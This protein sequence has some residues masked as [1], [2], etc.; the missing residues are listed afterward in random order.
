MVVRG[1]LRVIDSSEVSVI[2]EACVPLCVRARS[3][4]RGKRRYV[5][6]LLPL[7]QLVSIGIGVLEW[8]KYKIRSKNFGAEGGRVHRR[9]RWVLGAEVL[10][11]D[12]FPRSRE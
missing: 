3:G 1:V 2:E 4:G 11:R 6:R 10:G 8:E 12:G 9:G 5:T 7:P